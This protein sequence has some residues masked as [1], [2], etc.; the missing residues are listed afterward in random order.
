MEDEDAFEDTGKLLKK[1]FIFP[2]NCTNKATKKMRL[3]HK[4]CP[5]AREM[6]IVPGLHSTLVSV[7]KL[8]DAGYTTVFLKKGA[9]IY[10][11]HTTTITTNKPPLLEAKRCNLTG[12]WKLPLHPEGIAANGM[13]PH[14]E[15]INVIFNLPSARQNFLC[16]LPVARFPSKETFIKAVCNRNYATWPK[17]T[18][19]LIHKYMPDLD[20]MA[21]GHLKGQRQGV[22]STKQ[23]AFK[24]MIEV[25]EARVKNK[26]ESS[27]FRPLPPTKLNDI[28]VRMEDL[29]EEIHTNHKGAFPHTSQ[30][31]NHYIMVA[32]HL[33]ANYIFAKHMKNRTE[34]E[35]IRVYQKILN[36]MKAAGIGLKKQVLDNKCLAAIK[37]PIKE[38]SM[39]H[40]LIPPGQH[41]HNQAD[42]AIQTF[43]AHFISILAGIDDEF[44]LSLWC[45]LLKPT[46]LTLNLLCQSRV[47]P[48]ILAFAHVHGTH[49]YM[50]KPFAPIGCAVQTHVKLDNRLAWDTRS[51]PGFNLGTSMEY[52]QCFRVYVMRTRATRISGTVVFKHQ[53]TTS[54]TISPESH[55]VAA[56][57]Q[58]VTALKGNIPAGNETAEALTKVSK[59][60]TKNALAKKEVAKAKEQRNRLRANP[61]AWITTHLPRVAVTPPRVDVPVPRV[62]EATQAVCP[63]AQTGVSTTMMRPPV[64][65]LATRSSQP[66]RAD[67]WPTLSCPNYILQDKEDNDPPPERQTTRSAAWSTGSHVGMHQH[68]LHPLRRPRPPQLHFEPNQAHGNFTVTPQQMSMRHLPMAWFCEMANSVI[69]EGG[70]LLEY[71]QLTANPKTQAKWTHSS[72]GNEL[73]RLAQGMPGRN[74]STNT[75]I[76]IRKDQ[77]PTTRAKDVTYG[78][79]TCL[80]QPEK[81]DEPN[82]TRLVAGGDR[83]HYPGNTGTPTADLL[84]V[85]ILINSIISTPG[86]KFMTMDIK[87][88]YLNT[89]M[90]R[91]KYMQLHIA[92]MPDNIIE[93]YNLRDKATPDGYIY[94]KIQKGMYGLPQAGIIAQQLLE[95]RL[96]KHGYC[97]SQTTAGL[98]KHD[99]CP[100]S[101]SLVVDD[102][103]V[104]YVGKE[105]AQHLL[106]TVWHYYKCSCDW[107]G[108]QYCG[109]TLKWD[110]EGKKVHILMPGYVTKAL[111]RFQHPRPVKSQD[112]P[113]PHAKPNMGQRLS[114]PRQKTQP[115]S[116]TRQGRNLSKKCAEFSISLH[117]E[118]TAAYYPHSAP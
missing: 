1:T 74:T 78:L 10:D 103:G 61:L 17:L 30:R 33:D 88:F 94:C 73:G 85:K 76:F 102:F 18:V 4:L 89:L 66:P 75:I 47:A 3:K 19:Q 50:Q 29:N 65:T 95:E 49:N 104:K 96:Q 90:A 36:M 26:G 67:A 83:V 7:P 21:K 63:V 45:H 109:L 8:A 31:S 115:P 32:V 86:A 44:P 34:G 46:E 23:K 37:A 114:M 87:D 9:V 13:P 43:K 59:L 52:H 35:M 97:Q 118:S 11:D 27:P 2:D 71:K 69:G 98:W 48:K 24:K 117:A 79:I 39:D 107:K 60:F 57:Q 113:L 58:L 84:T 12:L 64:Q 28:F 40:K 25:E 100:I 68:L 70:E 42:R 20:E 111:P 92:D 6:N 54:P 105:N 116:T 99:T 108:E 55:V 81:L 5:A 106:D 53:Y 101:F 112:Q 80:V 93:H 56:A 72:H 51:E 91:Y 22:R 41:R 14:N 38:N 15:A 16:Y 62:A 77:V 82:R 110:Y